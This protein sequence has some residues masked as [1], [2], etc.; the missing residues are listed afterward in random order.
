M[1]KQS[2]SSQEREIY[3]HDTH[4]HTHTHSHTERQTE[5][6]SVCE[7]AHCKHM[8]AQPRAHA[9]HTCTSPDA[10]FRHDLRLACTAPYIR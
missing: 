10:L 2:I 5:R 6:E 9:G 4:T 7:I 1:E 3:T 8:R